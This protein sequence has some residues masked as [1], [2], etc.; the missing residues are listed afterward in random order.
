MDLVWNE[1]KGEQIRHATETAMR[2][3][4]SDILD[5]AERFIRHANEL[6]QQANNLQATLP[7]TKPERREGSY[8]DDN[9]RTR[10]YWYTIDV[11]D[12]I[13]TE[14]ARR[15]IIEWHNRE[16]R[17]KRYEKLHT[18]PPKIKESIKHA[19]NL[20]DILILTRKK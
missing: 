14:N 15:Q 8:E 3:Q 20:I 2:G 1:T 13:A 4:V 9:G 19:Y 18:T 17:Q 10:T 5:T 11:L 16:K 6:E 7:I 12:P